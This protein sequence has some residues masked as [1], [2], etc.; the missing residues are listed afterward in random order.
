MKVIFCDVDGVLISEDSFREAQ[1]SD[2]RAIM[3]DKTALSWLKW[4]A[5]ETGGRVVITS[6]WRPYSNQRPTMSYLWLKGVLVHNGTPVIGETPCLTQD[7]HSDRSDEI[8][9][10]LSERQVE[11][12]A[13]LDDNDR[14]SHHPEIRKHLVKINSACGLRE[15]DAKQARK[16]L[17]AT[18]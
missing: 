14:F 4:L 12:Y 11:A 2:K 16:L 18:K 7:G 8:S 13:V 5:D 17:N 10:W 6:S 3:F 15:K 9:A 1:L